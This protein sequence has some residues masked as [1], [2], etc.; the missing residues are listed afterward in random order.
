MGIMP[1]QLIARRVGE[2]TDATCEVR[3]Q[4]VKSNVALSQRLVIAQLREDGYTRTCTHLRAH[5]CRVTSFSLVCFDVSP[6]R[7]DVNG[8]K[9]AI[10]DLSGNKKIIPEVNLDLFSS[11]FSFLLLLP[12]SYSKP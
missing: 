8:E 9:N 6:L 1:R 4:S 11:L 12:L 2:Y 3:E 7:K 5:T 10:A